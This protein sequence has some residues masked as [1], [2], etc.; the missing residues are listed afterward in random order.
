MSNKQPEYAIETSREKDSFST[1][2]RKINDLKII[3]TMH[4]KPLH[5][6][7][8]SAC[9]V[10]GCNCTAFRGSPIDQFTWCQNCGHLSGYHGAY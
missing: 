3:S 10:R 7:N 5:V 1:I 4:S 9:Q 2:D 6:S 8:G